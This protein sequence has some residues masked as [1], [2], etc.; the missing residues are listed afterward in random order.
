MSQASV[1]YLA[2]LLH[3]LGL[4]QLQHPPLKP[5]L[6]PTKTNKQTPIKW[7]C[8]LKNINV[9]PELLMPLDL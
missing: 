4:T 6:N 5:S 1:G 8:L 7:C 9:V 2:I 3:N